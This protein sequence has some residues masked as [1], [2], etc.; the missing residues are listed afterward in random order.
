VLK[1]GVADYRMSSYMKRVREVK[2]PTGTAE[3]KRFQDM[4]TLFEKYRNRYG[5]GALMLAAQG[6]QESQLNQQ[7]KSHVGGIGVMQVMPVT[8]AQLG[9]GDITRVEP[10]IHAGAKYMDQLMSTYFPDARFSE[11]NRPLLA[12]ASHD[13]G[14]GHVAKARRIA[15]ERGLDPDK[16][17]D[18]VE[19]VV[20]E[21]I[22]TE[23]TSCVRN[24][25]KYYVAY[26]LTLEAQDAAQKARQH[27]LPGK[28]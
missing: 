4:L 17:F 26:R 12:F 20:A 18:N 21:K 6:Y 11:G 22:G 7:A 5:F 3:W 14:P 8:G 10:N 1:N 27:V 9:V 24:I 16:W 15:V 19:L 28:G 2:D 13:C 25:Y 23:T